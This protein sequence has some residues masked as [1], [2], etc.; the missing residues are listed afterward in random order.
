MNP[1]FLIFICQSLTPVSISVVDFRYPPILH[2]PIFINMAQSIKQ[3]T[4]F[5]V[6]RQ[7]PNF[8]QASSTLKSFLLFTYFSKK[9]ISDHVCAVN[10]FGSEN[11]HYVEAD[12]RCY[13]AEIKVRI[14]QTLHCLS[15]QTDDYLQPSTSAFLVSSIQ[16]S[17]R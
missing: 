10:D 6:H 8:S 12:R 2:R 15:K 16:I 7:H 3:S 1:L 13:K 11:D 4:R 5:T 9:K 14:Q 17:K